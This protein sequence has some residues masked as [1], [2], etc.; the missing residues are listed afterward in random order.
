MHQMC[1]RCLG[2]SVRNHAPD[3]LEP[4]SGIMHQM[5]W[6]LGQECLRASV[7]NV[8]MMLWNLGQNCAP[9]FGSIDHVHQNRLASCLSNE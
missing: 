3:A 2:A 9:D 6:S 8:H 5:P 1:T 7:R 4:R